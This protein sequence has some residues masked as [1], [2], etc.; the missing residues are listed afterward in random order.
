MVTF[1]PSS[2]HFQVFLS[3][4]VEI[5]CLQPIL[6][7]C[8]IS[9][10]PENVRK[11]EVFWCFQGVHKLNIGLMLISDFLSICIDN[12]NVPQAVLY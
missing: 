5:N 7:Q 1:N 11:P 3:P 4:G 10:P 12:C 9:I 6:S 2:I 8:S